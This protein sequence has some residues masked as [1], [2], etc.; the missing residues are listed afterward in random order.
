M[1]RPK[2][3]HSF[4]L[5]SIVCV[6]KRLT[7]FILLCYRTITVV[8]K[9]CKD[10]S[11]SCNARVGKPCLITMMG[12]FLFSFTALIKSATRN[13][14][15]KMLPYITINITNITNHINHGSVAF[16]SYFKFELWERS[17][18]QILS[19]NCIFDALVSVSVEGIVVIFKL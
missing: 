16:W 2:P 4:L 10:A 13:L 1:K 17:V 14:M 8:Q 11:V 3:N 19:T 6:F 15:P 5:M 18:R 7:E 12:F 9:I